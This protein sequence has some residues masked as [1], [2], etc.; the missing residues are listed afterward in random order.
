MPRG[1][2]LRLAT[3]ALGIVAAALFGFYM[4]AHLESNPQ[5]T[6]N[7][8]YYLPYS[9]VHMTG[10]GMNAGVRYDVVTV[11]P[12]AS[13]VT[14]ADP[15]NPIPP[16]PYDSVLAT[17]SGTFTYDYDL[18]NLQG[19]YTVNVYRHSDTAHTTLIATTTFED[20]LSPNLDQ[21]AN[22]SPAFGEFGPVTTSTAFAPRSRAIIAL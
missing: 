15:H 8:P 18:T 9:T 13:V 3:V 5:I 22:G 20:A 2:T 21:C 7:S 14:G 1:R 4:V 11:R 6:T 17:G 19:F 16:A 10:T 12:D